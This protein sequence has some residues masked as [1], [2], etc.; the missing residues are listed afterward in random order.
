M[1]KLITA[2]L[3]SLLFV[4]ASFAGAYVDY[5]PSQPKRSVKAIR[6]PEA[7]GLNLPEKI[8][9]RVEIKE[10]EKPL[11]PVYG[12]G[13]AIQHDVPAL[14]LI[15]QDWSLYGGLTRAGNDTYAMLKATGNIMKL[16]D[17][18]LVTG[19]L[20][21]FPWA[22]NGPAAVLTAGISRQLS[23]NLSVQFE[24]VPVYIGSGDFL[25]V[26]LGATYTF[27]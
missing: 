19:G 20:A 10:V 2:F 12:F 13:V 16:N 22:N 11:I 3:A 6:P 25:G 1:N 24:V 17:N 4:S 15:N 26:N 27:N 14:S 21:V 5:T 18:C 8:I 9:E 23:N 7:V